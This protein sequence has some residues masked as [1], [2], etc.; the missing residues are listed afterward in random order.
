[1]LKRLISGIR[2]NRTGKCKNRYW[3]HVVFLSLDAQ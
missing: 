2:F 3:I 1:V